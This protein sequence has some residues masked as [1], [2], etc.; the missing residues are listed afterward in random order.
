MCSK[1]NGIRDQPHGEN[2]PHMERK[3][4]PHRKNVPIGNKP[5]A[6]EFLKFM[7]PPPPDER[8]FLTPHLEAPIATPL[9]LFRLYERVRK[10]IYKNINEKHFS[11]SFISLFWWEGSPL[12][13]TLIISFVNSNSLIN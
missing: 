2:G 3:N 12:Y 5:P 8:L 9:T 13:Q 1:V 6:R 4:G 7:P 10:L 11:G